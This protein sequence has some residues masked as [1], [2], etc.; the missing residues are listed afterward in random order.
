MRILLVCSKKDIASV[1]FKEEIFS[2]Y[3][4]IKIKPNLYKIDI[5]SLNDI[6]IK[7]IDKMHIFLQEKEIIENEDFDQIIFLSK[8]STLSE[9][10]TKCMTVHAVGNWGKAELGG[11]DK[12]LVKTDPVLI[13]S[14][15]LN[16]KENKTKEIKEYEVKQ[17]ATHHGPFLET[18]TIF[19]EI[20]SDKKDWENKILANYM[21]GILINTIKNYNL[22]EIKKKEKWVSCVGIGGSHYCTKFNRFTFNRDKKYCFGHIVPNYALDKINEKIINYAKENS[23]SEKIIKEEDLIDL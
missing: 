7:D 8:H 9:K 20:G 1:N 6:F 11:K 3:N 5:E 4:L 22:E 16:L 12:T 23:S 17:E 21:I 15:L 14:L 2:K 18:S 10:K 19:F 13:R